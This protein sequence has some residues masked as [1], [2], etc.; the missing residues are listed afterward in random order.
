M[1]PISLWSGQG[2]LSAG[3]TVGWGEVILSELLDGWI[4]LLPPKLPGVGDVREGIRW[5][6]TD[7]HMNWQCLEDPAGRSLSGS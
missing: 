4:S 1:F 2:C 3:M 6:H 7:M 5:T